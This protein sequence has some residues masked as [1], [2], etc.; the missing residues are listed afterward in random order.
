MGAG[1]PGEV[2][3]S[4]KLAPNGARVKSVEMYVPVPAVVPLV[5]IA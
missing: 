5:L 1:T 3:E 2:L 4:L